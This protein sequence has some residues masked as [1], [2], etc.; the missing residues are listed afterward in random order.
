MWFANYVIRVGDTAA[1]KNF[2]SKNSVGKNNGI[3]ANEILF[4]G[5]IIICTQIAMSYKKDF[6]TLAQ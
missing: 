6:F 1:A 5:F 3:L 2:A 4:C